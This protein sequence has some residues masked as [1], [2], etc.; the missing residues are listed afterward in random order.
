MTWPVW[1]CED[2]GYIKGK[3]EGW[4]PHW[5]PRNER[6]T[7]EFLEWSN[8]QLD[9]A[10]QL[11]EERSGVLFAAPVDDPPDGN[12]YE[13]AVKRAEEGDKSLLRKLAPKLAPPEKRDGRRRNPFERYAVRW[14]AM[15]AQ[16]EADRLKK[17]WAKEF[18][19]QNRPAGQSAREIATR[20]WGFADDKALHDALLSG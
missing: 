6:E 15:E 13:V 3:D 1:S 17:I 20:R 10:V 9:L 4:K 16:A 8:K 18:G 7:Q 11:D 12:I 5:E 2:K 14:R 19:K